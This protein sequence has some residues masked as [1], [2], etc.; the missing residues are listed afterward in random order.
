MRLEKHTV[1][2]RGVVCTMG[3]VVVAVKMESAIV[4]IVPIKIAVAEL[5]Q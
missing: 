2:V 1:V 4:K 5:V 3:S